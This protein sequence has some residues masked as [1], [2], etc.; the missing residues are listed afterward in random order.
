MFV[1]KKNMCTIF[2]ILLHDVFPPQDLENL[3]EDVEWFEKN[4]NPCSKRI[5]INNS[6]LTMFGRRKNMYQKVSQAYGRLVPHI[7]F[8]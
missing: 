8:D 4:V 7:Y 1:G 3:Y 6:R 2:G 5:I